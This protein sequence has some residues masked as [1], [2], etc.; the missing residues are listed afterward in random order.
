MLI[1]LRLLNRDSK[2]LRP[3]QPMRQTLPYELGKA[4]PSGAL[5]SGVDRSVRSILGGVPV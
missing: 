4:C 2:F 1:L 3:G 5:E